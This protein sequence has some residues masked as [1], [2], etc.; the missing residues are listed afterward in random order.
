MLGEGPTDR[1]RR[2]AAQRKHPQDLDIINAIEMSVGQESGWKRM[3][4]R[5]KSKDD[6]DDDDERIA[7]K[8]Y[9]IAPLT[10]MKT[11]VQARVETSLRRPSASSSIWRRTMLAGSFARPLYLVKI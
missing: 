4:E 6:D 3:S 9:L 8:L 10:S 11:T 1:L 7:L 5:K 2:D